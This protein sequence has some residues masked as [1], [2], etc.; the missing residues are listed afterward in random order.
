MLEHGWQ[1]INPC[2]CLISC[3]IKIDTCLI[4]Q[5]W[6][7]MMHKA[8][9]WVDELSTMIKHDINIDLAGQLNHD[10]AWYQVWSSICE[11][12]TR[13]SKKKVGGMQRAL[14]SCNSL[15]NNLLR[16]MLWDKK[17][18]RRVA[19]CLNIPWFVIFSHYFW[20]SLS[21]CSLVLWTAVNRAKTR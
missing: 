16:N 7:G 14:M 3:L 9:T 17:L 6:S 8:W 1:F 11:I 12:F 19:M 2:S 18:T 4:G 5:P 10:Q 13:V 21:W 20:C 15:N